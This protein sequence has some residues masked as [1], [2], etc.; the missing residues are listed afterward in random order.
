MPLPRLTRQRQLQV[1]A[2]VTY[3]TSPA[4]GTP[5]LALLDISD[6]VLTDQTPYQERRTMAGSGHVAGT[7]GPR[8]AQVTFTSHAFGDASDTWMDVLLPACGFADVTGTFTPTMLPPQSAGSGAHAVTLRW[9]ADGVMHRVSAAM[10]NLVIDA[11][12][13]QRVA[14][15]WTFTGVYHIGEDVVLPTY[16]I[17]TAAPIVASSSA[18]VLGAY[19]PDV[20]RTCQIDLRN[21]V[22]VR[23]SGAAANQGAYG[24]V[25]ADRGVRMQASIEAQLVAA[26]NPESIAALRTQIACSLTLGGAGNQVVILAPAAQIESPVGHSDQNGIHMHDLTLTCNRDLTTDATGNNELTIAPN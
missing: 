25:I 15:N 12:A 22:V 5:P 7:L 4:V 26:F 16:T 23:E 21:Q 14:L 6:P 8:V 11:T 18:L 3:G 13:G 19:T 24:A 20:W 10:G 1:Q 17:P 9:S 2:E